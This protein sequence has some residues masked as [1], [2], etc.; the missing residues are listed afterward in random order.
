MET[1]VCIYTVVHAQMYD[2]TLYYSGAWC[3]IGGAALLVFALELGKYI[4]YVEKRK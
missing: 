2:E 1:G 3:C 4:S